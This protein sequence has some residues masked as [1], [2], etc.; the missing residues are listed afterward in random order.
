MSSSVEFDRDFGSL[1]RRKKKRKKMEFW[2]IIDNMWRIVEA[3]EIV[4]IFLNTVKWDFTH[5][6]SHSMFRSEPENYSAIQTRRKFYNKKISLESK[7]RKIQTNNCSRL[8]Q[9]F[10]SIYTV[11]KSGALQLLFPLANIDNKFVRKAK[12]FPMRE[13]IVEKLETPLSDHR[14]TEV[15]WKELERWK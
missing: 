12:Y 7:N 13:K 6:Q 11:T 9:N 1:E 10:H 14:S 3:R 2:W 8:S 5:T 4:N 15:N